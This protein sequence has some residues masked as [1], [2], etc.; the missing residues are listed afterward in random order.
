MAPGW[1]ASPSLASVAAR[2]VTLAICSAKIVV[3]VGGMCCV[4]RIGC[5]TAPNPANSVNSACGPPVEE[6][7]AMISGYSMG[8]RRRGISAPRA[9]RATGASRGGGGAE[10][11]WCGDADG[12]TGAGATGLTA[13]VGRCGVSI[14]CERFRPANALIFAIRSCWKA[15][16]EVSS[17][18]DDGLAI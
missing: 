10:G 13:G 5:F 14:L 17:L 4:I 6:P 7:I 18:V 12:A 11:A 1:I 15:C 3:K 9:S 8:A 2:P 16:A